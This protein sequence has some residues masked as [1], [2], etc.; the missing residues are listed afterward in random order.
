MLQ[1]LYSAV[2]LWGDAARAIQC[3]KF[4]KPKE[5]YYEEMLQELYSV[6]ENDE[7]DGEVNI[8][9]NDHDSALLSLVDHDEMRDM[10]TTAKLKS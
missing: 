3:C 2:S 10:P 4:M 8:R 1:E 5:G 6:F 7:I 9:D